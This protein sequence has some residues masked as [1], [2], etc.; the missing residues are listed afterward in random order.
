MHMRGMFRHEFLDIERIR[1]WTFAKNTKINSTFDPIRKECR[2][3]F[4]DGTD[5]KLKALGDGK[6]HQEQTSWEI[7]GH[8]DFF[9][10]GVRF[11]ASGTLTRHSMART[12]DGGPL[13]HLR[14]L[15][16]YVTEKPISRCITETRWYPAK[17]HQIATFWGP[18]LTDS[19]WN[20]VR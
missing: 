10:I 14:C 7:V 8:V 20:Y 11:S 3:W 17:M 5:S 15:P 13:D 4:G 6:R 9:L 16:A 12:D 1:C 19:L 18:L 2:L